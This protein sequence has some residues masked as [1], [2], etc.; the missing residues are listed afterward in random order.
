M[1]TC[2][3]CWRTC[4]RTGR[5]RHPCPKSRRRAWL[6]AS[7]PSLSSGCG[8]CASCETI[9]QPPTAQPCTAWSCC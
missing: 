1:A 5:R 8:C 6:T 2:S 3:G 9:S 4:R 7:L